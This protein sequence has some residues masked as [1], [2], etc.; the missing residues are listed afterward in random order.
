MLLPQAK[1]FAELF[2][3]P[4]TPRMPSGLFPTITDLRDATLAARERTGKAG[5]GTQMTAGRVQVVHVTYP[6]GERYA[7][8]AQPMSGRLSIADAIAFLNRLR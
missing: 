1:T 8:R 5:I 6:N 4:E 2:A 3:Q 7:G